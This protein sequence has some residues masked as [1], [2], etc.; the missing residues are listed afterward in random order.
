MVVKKIHWQ[1]GPVE[2]WGDEEKER[3]VKMWIL[4]DKKDLDDETTLTNAMKPYMDWFVKD[5]KTGGHGGPMVDTHSNRVIGHWEDWGTGIHPEEK[6]LGMW[7]E[8]FVHRGPAEKDYKFPAADAVWNDMKSGLAKGG[9]WG[10][11]KMEGLFEYDVSTGEVKGNTLTDVMPYEISIIRENARLNGM[12]AMPA[13]PAATLIELADGAKGKEI[14]PQDPDRKSGMTEAIPPDD[15]VCNCMER[16]GWLGDSAKAF[17]INLYTEGGKGVKEFFGAPRQSI[18]IA[19]SI[20]RSRSRGTK[21]PNDAKSAVVES[22]LAARYLGLRLIE[23]GSEEKAL[24]DL[25]RVLDGEKEIVGQI[26][27][28]VKEMDDE[29][30][31]QLKTSVDA[32]TSE[33]KALREA[34]KSPPPADPKPEGKE[35]EAPAPAEDPAVKEMKSKIAALE[36]E[37]KS[38]KAKKQE[39][40]EKP[41][42]GEKPDEK[43]EDEEEKK[44]EA[45]EAS[46]DDLTP[47]QKAQ[48][49]KVIEAKVAE[50]KKSFIAKHVRKPTPAPAGSRPPIVTPPGDRKV[51][52]NPNTGKPY[53]PQDLRRMTPEQRTAAGF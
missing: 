37:M 18:E 2:T 52:T 21:I 47:E 40:E 51:P 42:E 48:L 20:S 53:A 41:E 19:E 10:G 11:H 25:Q 31:K 4:V 32:L 6:V 12:P 7:V 9:S 1:R 14:T 49:E 39:E 29:T 30:A 5:T 27:Q 23:V 3:K 35:K 17:C 28:E 22:P 33:M 46:L 38:L 24:S 16:V 44:K 43:P 45:K 13:Q 26:R 50:E 15:W 34:T 36:A 8:G